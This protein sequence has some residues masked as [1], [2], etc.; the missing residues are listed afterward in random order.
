M[1]LRSLPS[2]EMTR[3]Y[4]WGRLPPVA[5]ACGVAVAEGETRAGSPCYIEHGLEARATMAVLEGCGGVFACIGG[6]YLLY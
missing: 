6:R 5:I 4:G 1:C 2:V 3:G